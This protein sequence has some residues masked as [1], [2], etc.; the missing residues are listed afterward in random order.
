MAA[1]DPITGTA[2]K[3]SLRAVKRTCL[4]CGTEDMKKG[5]RY[6]S[7]ECR[8][9]IHWVLSL[10]KG[11]LRTLNARYAAFS[12]TRDMVMLD[13]YPSWSQDISRFSYDRKNGRKPAEDLKCLV[14]QWGREWHSIVGSKKSRSYAS[15]TLINKTNQKGID[16]EDVKPSRRVQPRLS[17]TEASSLKVLKLSRKDLSSDGSRQTIKSAYKK[18]AKIHHPDVG[19]DAEAFKQLQN[20]HEQMLQWA[21]NPQYTFRKALVGCWFYDGY[22]GRWSPPL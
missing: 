9:K 18:M 5:R 20:A 2:L 7:K 10:S 15:L 16:P 17:R 3:P 1:Q 13:V 19:G 12:F 11:L 4:S 21:E 14:V 8:E 6:C 22:T